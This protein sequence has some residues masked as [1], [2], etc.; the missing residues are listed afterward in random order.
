MC[1]VTLVAGRVEGSLW[2]SLGAGP[3][4]LVPSLSRT[5]LMHI[6]SCDGALYPFVVKKSKPGIQLYFESFES[7]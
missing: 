2:I 6:F 3:L 5:R 4:T 1:A 7:P